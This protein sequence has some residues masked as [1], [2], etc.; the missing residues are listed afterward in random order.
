MRHHLVILF[1]SAAAGGPGG[2]GSGRV[3]GRKAVHLEA[4]GLGKQVIWGRNNLNMKPFSLLHAVDGGHRV[5]P[6]CPRLAP[7]LSLLPCSPWISV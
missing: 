1:S 6:L 4:C 2:V 7:G 3:G 5:R